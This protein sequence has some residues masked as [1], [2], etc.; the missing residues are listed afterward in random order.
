MK[1]QACASPIAFIQPAMARNPVPDED[2]LGITIWPLNLG[3][4]RSCHE[5]G[6]GAPAFFCSTVLTH[7]TASQASIPVQAIGALAD[8]NSGLSVSAP[9]GV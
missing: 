5:A 9:F 3:S 4:V 2:G 8:R 1:V 6:I 7:T